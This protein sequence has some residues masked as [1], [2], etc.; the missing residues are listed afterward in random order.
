[1]YPNLVAVSAFSLLLLAG[2]GKE[3]ATEVRGVSP[4]EVVSTSICEHKNALQEGVTGISSQDAEFVCRAM[5]AKLG[6]APSPQLLATMQKFLFG[7]RANYGMRD[8]AKE[9]TEQ[10]MAIVEA[11]RQLERADADIIQTLNVAAKCYSGSDGRVSLV[12]IASALHAS[13]DAA[14]TMSEDGIYSMCAT[15]EVMK[16]NRNSTSLHGKEL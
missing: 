12:D 2:C 13:G 10:A 7:L 15:I 1:M 9:F 8:S 16:N 6:R 11:R 14:A 5:N 3:V 4:S